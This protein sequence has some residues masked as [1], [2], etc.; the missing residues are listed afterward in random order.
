[1][2]RKRISEEDLLNFRKQAGE[3]AKVVEEKY[4]RMDDEKKAEIE[5]EPTGYRGILLIHDAAEN[6]K[7][8]EGFAEKLKA[9]EI[10]ADIADLDAGGNKGMFDRTPQWQKWLEAAQNAYQSIAERCEKVIVLGTGISCPLA[11]VIAEQ[12]SVDALGHCGRRS[13]EGRICVFKRR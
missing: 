4:N 12:Y 11:C 2:A 1:M 6:A 7:Q 3:L 10:V 8:L 9:K 13:Q 5:P